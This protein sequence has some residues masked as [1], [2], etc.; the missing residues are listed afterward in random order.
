MSYKFTV[1][2]VIIIVCLCAC[3]T[4]KTIEQQFPT[5]IISLDDGYKNALLIT[6]NDVD[7][8]FQLRKAFDE[9]CLFSESGHWKL[10]KQKTK[11]V[12]F[13][14]I[15]LEFDYLIIE[16]NRYISKKWNRIFQNTNNRSDMYQLVFSDS[17][18]DNK[19]NFRQIFKCAEVNVYPK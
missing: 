9:N 12:L 11:I 1:A 18:I 19:Q 10:N 5:E 16:K 14:E 17:L 13:D 8:S 15:G 2:F 3:R 4:R 6:F 7:F